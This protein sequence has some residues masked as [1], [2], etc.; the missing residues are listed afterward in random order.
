MSVRPGTG[1]PLLPLACD[2]CFLFACSYCC[3]LFSCSYCCFLPTRP[4]FH[5]WCSPDLPPALAVF[6]I[7]SLGCMIL[8]LYEL[9]AAP[10]PVG[11]FNL[12]VGPAPMW[13]HASPDPGCQVFLS[14][15]RPRP[16]LVLPTT[17]HSPGSPGCAAGLCVVPLIRSSHANDPSPPVSCVSVFCKS[18]DRLLHCFLC[19]ARASTQLNGTCPAATRSG[20]G[21][22]FGTSRRESR[23]K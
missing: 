13:F 8:C 1:S 22:L 14:L 17:T 5:P 16:P 4:G 18:S 12:P 10:P 19:Q 3:F 23:S 11:P 21:M 7:S 15:P 20:G 2:C 9:S 6:Q